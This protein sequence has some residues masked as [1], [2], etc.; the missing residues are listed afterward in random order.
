MNQSDAV[1]LHILV[2]DD[3]SVN[4]HMMGLLL[5]SRGHIVDFA[6][7][8]LEALD[9]VKNKKYDIVFMDLQMPVMDGLESSRRIRE[10][11]KDAGFSTFIVALTASFLPE[12]GGELFAVGIDNYIAKPF[13]VD[14]IYRIVSYCSS[15]SDRTIQR[16][17]GIP[18]G[19]SKNPE[20]L[21]VQAGL[22][23]L[24][25]NLNMYTTLL[26]EFLGELQE[27]LEVLQ[28]CLF[29]DDFQGLARAAHNLK[30]VSASLGALQ[31]SEYAKM[32]ERHSNAGYTSPL[33]GLL[34]K[35]KASG[36][37]LK[38]AG[39]VFLSNGGSTLN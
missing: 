20:V 27:R 12:K 37:A 24:G 1:Q 15:G 31:L 10:W 11:E 36:Y 18:A 17:D 8:G 32:L 23:R 16:Q 30:G 29:S 4:Q 9:A 5:T 33:P 6:S 3:D 39:Q 35:I 25:G 38:Q 19:E 28:G 34:T 14:Q 26:A 22:Q 2:V 7:N 13:K 21:D